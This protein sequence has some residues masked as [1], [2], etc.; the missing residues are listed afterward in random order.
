MSLSSGRNC[1]EIA[2]MQDYALIMKIVRRFRS[3]WV[4]SV[5]TRVVDE[6]IVSCHSH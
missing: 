5:R 2:E 4:A 1:P 6:M 3:A